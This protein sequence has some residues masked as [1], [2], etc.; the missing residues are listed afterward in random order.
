MDRSNHQVAHKYGVL[1]A[2]WLLHEL[3]NCFMN[4]EQLAP[5]VEGDVTEHAMLNFVPFARVERKVADYDRDPFAICPI[6]QAFF[7]M[8]AA[9][10]IATPAVAYDEDF[11]ASG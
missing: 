1:F 5:P 10:R 7:P 4:D 9:C 11:F 6:L 8:S 2:S 3:D